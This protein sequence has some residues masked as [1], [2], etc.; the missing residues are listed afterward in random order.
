[1]CVSTDRACIFF[2]NFVGWDQ[3]QRTLLRMMRELNELQENQ[4]PWV[5][6]KTSGRS[7]VSGMMLW[8]TYLRP[9]IADFYSLLTDWTEHLGPVL[10]LL[11]SLSSQ[12]LLLNSHLQELDLG[13]AA[14]MVCTYLDEKTCIFRCTHDVC[15]IFVCCCCGCWCFW[16]PLFPIQVQ[17]W[18]LLDCKNLQVNASR[19]RGWRRHANL[20]GRQQHPWWCYGVCGR[21]GLGFHFFSSHIMWQVFLPRV[22]SLKILNVLLRESA[23]VLEE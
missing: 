14:C 9:G 18:N 17:A 15:H 23:S 3:A 12:A 6:C 2:K 22:D 5:C 16:M 20:C 1:M 10:R 21:G 13:R 7:I 11:T 19:K 4:T 8:S